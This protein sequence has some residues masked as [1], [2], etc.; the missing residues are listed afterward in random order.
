M[1]IFLINKSN[2]F[3]LGKMVIMLNIISLEFHVM[4]ACNL[5]C[6]QCSHY[7]NLQIGGG[8]ISLNSAENNY[9]LWYNRV[10]PTV[11]AL[12]GGEPT[13]NPYLLDH[14]LL[15]KKYWI[16]S[17]LILV[18]NGFF[19]D[20]H[21][22]L[23]KVLTETDCRLE[24]SQHGTKE[25]Y[26][27]KF[28]N[29]IEILKEWRLKYPELKVNIRQSHKGWIRQ[30]NISDEG[31]PIPFN[32]NPEQSYSICMQKTCTQIY[33]NKLWKCP[34]L[35]YFKLLDK[36]IKLNKEWDLF[37]TYNGLDYSCDDKELY[38]FFSTK[39][40]SQCSLC[41]SHK[42]RFAHPDPVNRDEQL[43]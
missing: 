1:Y 14:I 2:I 13:L 12:L 24:I 6:Q 17:K 42:I 15:A 4:H 31:K 39:E 32:S 25:N 11:F 35:A 34:A 27:E 41:P 36:K 18:S 26:L 23:P 9:L 38:E 22:D 19:L 20:K 8:I 21:P 7:S 28:N 5:F 43:I 37:R 30:Y 3:N 33:D 10:Q 40:I 29:S 16:N